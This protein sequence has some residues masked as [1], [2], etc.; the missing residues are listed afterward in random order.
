MNGM[1]KSNVIVSEDVGYQSAWNLPHVQFP[2]LAVLGLTT[3]LIP[4][5]S[6]D[7]Q[8]NHED[9]IEVGED[10]ADPAGEAPRRGLHQVSSVVH[11][12]RDAP[13]ARQQQLAPPLL[14]VAALVGG[15]DVL[16]DGA[17]D[18]GLSVGA[19]EVVL[20]V[21]DCPEDVV[22][23]CAEEEDE[24]EDGPGKLDGVGDQVETLK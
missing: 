13:P 12:P 18:G 4:L 8:N 6:M 14:A 5:A 23:G 3:I 16:G 1:A 11:V 20:L 21:V 9:E 10:V 19:P 2:G 24:G 7:Q 17:P 22:P 15:V